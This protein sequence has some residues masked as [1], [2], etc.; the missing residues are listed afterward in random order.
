M[1]VHGG[2][3]RIDSAMAHNGILLSRNFPSVGGD[4][5]SLMVV[6]HRNAG[7]KYEGQNAKEG[8]QVGPDIDCL[9]VPPEQ[10]ES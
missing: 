9:V 10:A 5:V 6:L 3:T 4:L 1:L 8:Q 7:G 2:Q